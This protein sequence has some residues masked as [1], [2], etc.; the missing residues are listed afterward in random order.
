M[1]SESLLFRWVDPIFTIRAGSREEVQ[2]EG[3]G[4]H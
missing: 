2:V 1:N 4:R 3:E